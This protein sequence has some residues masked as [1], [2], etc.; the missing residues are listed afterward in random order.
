MASFK[1]I[2]LSVSFLSDNCFLKCL[3]TV[4]MT[5]ICSGDQVAHPFM[6]WVTK[7]FVQSVLSWSNKGG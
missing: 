3:N 6:N 1:A 4:A 5:E 7:A 2:C